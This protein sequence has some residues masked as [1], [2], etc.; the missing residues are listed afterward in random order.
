MNMSETEGQQGRTAQA[1][2]GIYFKE[3]I[4]FFFKFEPHKLKAR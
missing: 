2:P 4:F 3:S 1:V